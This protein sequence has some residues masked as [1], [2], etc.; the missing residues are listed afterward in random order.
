MRYVPPTPKHKR[1][2]AD[3]LERFNIERLFAQIENRDSLRSPYSDPDRQVSGTDK[4][5]AI[6]TRRDV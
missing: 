6:L 5:L 2:A 4:L 3:K 1:K